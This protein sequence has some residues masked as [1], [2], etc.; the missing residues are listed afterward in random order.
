MEQGL[1]NVEL[2]GQGYTWVNIGIHESLV[3]AINYV[4]TMEPHRYRKIACL[5]ETDHLNG[6]LS[7]EGV[8]TV[9]EVLKK[10]QYG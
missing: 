4:K 5:E 6:W 8:L 2:L 9:D 1:P 7:K 3:D 10:N